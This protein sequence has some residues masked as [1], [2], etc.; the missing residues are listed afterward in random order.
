[1]TVLMMTMFTVMD[2]NSYQNGYCIIV[3][4]CSKSL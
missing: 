2:S 4:I 1:M 3:F